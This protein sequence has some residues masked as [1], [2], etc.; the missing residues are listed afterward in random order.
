[1]D[2]TLNKTTNRLGQTTS[3]VSERSSREATPERGRT[4]ERARS[5]ETDELFREFNRAAF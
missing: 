3:D 5:L 1:M 2:R 4:P